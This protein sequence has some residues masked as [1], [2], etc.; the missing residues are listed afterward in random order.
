[1]NIAK[2]WL[3]KLVVA[4]AMLLLANQSHALST[5][6]MVQLSNGVA[7]YHSQLISS[8][9]PEHQQESRALAKALVDLSKPSTNVAQ[10]HTRY[11]LA[12]LHLGNYAYTDTN[13]TGPGIEVFIAF[14]NDAGAKITEL[15]IRTNALNEFVRTRKAASIQLNQAYELLLITLA[16]SGDF[17]KTN[18]QANLV[19]GHRIFSKLVKAE[20]LVRRGEANQGY[21]PTDGIV[22]G[23]TLNYTAGD[24]VGSFTFTD[25]TNYTQTVG[26]NVAVG[27]YVSTRT[28]LHK[29]TIVLSETG[30]GVTTVNARFTAP[31]IGRFTYRFVDAFESGRGSGRFTLTFP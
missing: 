15:S 12:T 14:M 26:T 13:I 2:S 9:L 4:A 22:V 8:P 5:P 17:S 31:G 3:V 20:K 30:G 16:N 28:A 27:T 21:A 11:F 10:D 25:E 19:R 24:E 29:M 1:M 6:Y 7:F 23:G 18:L